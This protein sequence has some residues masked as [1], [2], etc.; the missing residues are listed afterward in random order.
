M[1]DSEGW[2]MHHSFTNSFTKIK[3][4]WLYFIKNSKNQSLLYSDLLTVDEDSLLECD[5]YKELLADKEFRKVLANNYKNEYGIPINDANIKN[6]FLNE[7]YKVNSLNTK[8]ACSEL[9][10]FV[11]LSG[12]FGIKI[13]IQ[14]IPVNAE[15]VKNEVEK[16]LIQETKEDKVIKEDENKLNNI[17]NIEAADMILKN[18]IKE[19]VVLENNNNNNNISIIENDKIIPEINN[20]QNIDNSV[21]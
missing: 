7:Y 19:E 21:N 15:Q 18:D 4:H 5:C 17:P 10:D 11:K 16:V 1:H 8:E 9:A 12:I 13:P 20:D 3:S 2:R 14:T 6:F